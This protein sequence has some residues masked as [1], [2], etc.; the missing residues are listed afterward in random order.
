[1]SEGK[2][3]PEAVEQL[4]IHMIKEALEYVRAIG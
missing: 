1:M 3:L 2:S 4:E